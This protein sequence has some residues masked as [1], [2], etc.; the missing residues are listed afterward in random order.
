ML[1]SVTGV[2]V[3][4]VGPPLGGVPGASAATAGTA[5]VV[6]PAN[7]APLNAGG[8]T[9][10]FRFKLPASSACT[11]DSTNDGYRVHSYIVPHSVDLD[12][13]R[14][15]GD[16]PVVVPGE[17]RKPM[18]EDGTGT[19]FASVQTADR[20]APGRPGS[21]IQP[22]PAFSFFG[23]NDLPSSD[24]ES[25][26]LPAGT[27]N[28]GI[29]CVLG[30]ATSATQLDRYWNAVMTLTADPEDRPAR[31]TWEVTTPAGGQSAQSSGSTVGRTAGV[32]GA[33][34]V[35]GGAVLVF[36]RRRGHVTTSSPSPSR[37]AKET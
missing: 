24:V 23:Y 32:A 14:F 6:D 2:A 30:A 35:A 29:A 33:A 27:Y 37:P 25:F 4:V 21:V 31:V 10:A 28:L 34:L 15:T 5:V 17:L 19:Q 3:S 12:S 20:T 1:G 7:G 9:T 22:L 8:S 36:R 16:G 26:P 13:L 18:Y 11:G